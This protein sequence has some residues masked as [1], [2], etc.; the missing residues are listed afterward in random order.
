MIRVVVLTPNRRRSSYR[1]GR[2]GPRAGRTG[3]GGGSSE[4]ATDDAG[5]GTTVLAGPA[6]GTVTGPVSPVSSASW[7]RGTP[8]RYA[9]SPTSAQLL[10]YTDSRLPSSA[11]TSTERLAAR[12]SRLTTAASLA[13]CGVRTATLGR[14]RVREKSATSWSA[15]RRPSSMVTTRSA[16]R[17]A[18]LGSLVVCRTVPPSAACARSRPCSQPFSRGERPLAGSSRTSVCGSPSSADAIPRRRSMPAERAPMRWSPSPA[19]PTTSSSSSARDA[20]TPAAAQ[21]IRSWPRA[22]RA[23]WPGTSPRSTP[24]SRAGWPMRCRGRPRK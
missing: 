7:C 13:A 2:S 22:V 20:G 21:S 4:T 9:A 17:A 12:A 1:T 16:A 23:G 10:P 15:T 8:C 18:S 24:T 11:T 6:P 19:R 5:P 14:R 3:I